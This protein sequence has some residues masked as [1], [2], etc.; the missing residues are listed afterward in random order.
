M[1]PKAT[2]STTKTAVR[3]LAFAAGMLLAAGVAFGQAGRPGGD[4]SAG[5]TAGRRDGKTPGKH[6]RQSVDVEA[7]AK[8]YEA[9]RFTTLDG[10]TMGYR[11]MKPAGYA[12]GLSYPMVVCLHGIPGQGTGNLLQ[13][14]ATYPV[15]VLARPAMRRQYPCFVLAPQ[16]PNW[17]GD[18]PYG[19]TTP[20]PGRRHFPAMSV[21]LEL[22]DKLDREFDLDPNRIYVTGHAMGGFGTFNA[23]QADPNM[24]AAAVVVSGGG[25]PNSAGKFAHI[26]VWI[27]AGEKSPILHYPVDMFKA[28]KAAGG[29]PKLTILNGAPTACWQEVYDSQAVWDWLFAQRRQ[30]KLPTTMPSTMPGATQPA[31]PKP[32]IIYSENGET[33][34]Y[35]P[36]ER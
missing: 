11:L 14:G 13:L 26:P 25:D 7:L 4:S 30:P 28:L 31:T 8:L 1:A 36:G 19:N 22:V 27:F 9:R 29:H 5:P 24:W 33:K 15:D 18:Q 10:K 21:L 20:K 32:K 6:E 34:E 35:R 3:I 23:L 12:E 17:W 2:G 16:S